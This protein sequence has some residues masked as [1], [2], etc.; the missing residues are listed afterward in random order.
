M[1]N[2]VRLHF[3]F[4]RTLY[5]TLAHMKRIR[6]FALSVCGHAARFRVYLCSKKK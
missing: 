2:G 4:Q 6:D 5:Q 3:V 1:A